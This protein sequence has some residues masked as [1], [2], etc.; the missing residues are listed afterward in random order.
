MKKI[1]CIQLKSYPVKSARYIRLCCWC[2][3][4]PNLIHC[5]SLLFWDYYCWTRLYVRS[6]HVLTCSVTCQV[7]VWPYLTRR[8]MTWQFCHEIL[9]FN[10]SN[11]F[12]SPL[13]R[14]LV[15]IAFSQ[16]FGSFF[17]LSIQSFWS[18]PFGHL[19][20]IVSTQVLLVILSWPLR[21]FGKAVRF[22]VLFCY[23]VGFL[24]FVLFIFSLEKEGG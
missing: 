7:K 10:I 18:P 19:S 3:K 6:W 21:H 1:R 15:V 2:R 11:P 13:C 9:S 24:F 14:L 20:L 16:Y 22:L 17:V 8:R 23:C 12:L 4:I 5:C